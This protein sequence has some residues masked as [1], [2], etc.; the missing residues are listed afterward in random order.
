MGNVGVNV[1]RIET[2][3]PSRNVKKLEKDE[4][5]DEEFDYN[6]VKSTLMKP[7][8]I[9]YLNYSENY[10]NDI[11]NKVKPKKNGKGFI[12]YIVPLASTTKPKQSSFD[13]ESS[14]QYDSAPSEISTTESDHKVSAHPKNKKKAKDG[15]GSIKDLQMTNNIC[16]K[17]VLRSRISSKVH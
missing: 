6:S 8:Q 1:V 9:D 13:E 10:L 4:E 16:W 14:S 2:S 7:G 12:D 15:R 3:R 11:K 17:S 5:D